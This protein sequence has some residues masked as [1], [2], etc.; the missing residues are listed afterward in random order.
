MKRTNVW[1]VREARARL[2]ELVRNTRAG[3]PQTVTMCGKASVVFI[4]PRR[5]VVRRKPKLKQATVRPDAR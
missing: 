5:F 4:D 2:S 3:E 1:T